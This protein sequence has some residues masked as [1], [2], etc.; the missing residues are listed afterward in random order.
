MCPGWHIR[1]RRVRRRHWRVLRVPGCCW[2]LSYVL[3][4]GRRWDHVVRERN[5]GYSEQM[6]RV[7]LVPTG[8]QSSRRFAVAE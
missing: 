7:Q 2:H 4:E 1:M 3:G 8:E 5:E 6:R